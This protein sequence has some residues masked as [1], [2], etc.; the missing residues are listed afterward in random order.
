MSQ[1]SNGPCSALFKSVTCEIDPVSVTLLFCSAGI[2]GFPRPC[3]LSGENWEKHWEIS[4]GWAVCIHCRRV[5]FSY[6]YFQGGMRLAFYGSVGFQHV[7]F[8]YK[9][10]PWGGVSSG[11]YLT[12]QS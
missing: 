5:T 3:W 7:G 4:V 10:L 6:C 2:I 8:D 9:D 11:I 12:C 1:A